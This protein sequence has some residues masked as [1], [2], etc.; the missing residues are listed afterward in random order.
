MSHV[1]VLY[2]PDQDELAKHAPPPSS[3]GPPVTRSLSSGDREN[4]PTIVIKEVG[5]RREGEA[6]G[7]GARG[8]VAA[9]GEAS[10]KTADTHISIL[11]K[12]ISEDQVSLC[13][14]AALHCAHVL[15]KSQAYIF[16]F[17]C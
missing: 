12:Y 1:Q 17:S 8:E 14:Y 2:L 16:V 3:T 11:S 9:E 6:R 5:E 13:E 15:I 4:T 10:P 7:E